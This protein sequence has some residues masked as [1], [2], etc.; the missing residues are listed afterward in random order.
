LWSSPLFLVHPEDHCDRVTQRN[1]CE[2]SQQ[3]SVLLLIPVSC[4]L[5]GCTDEQ[6]FAVDSQRLSRLEPGFERLLGK[7]ES[8]PVKKP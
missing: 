4:E 2:A 7:L 3:L 5:I 6:R 8:R 1:W